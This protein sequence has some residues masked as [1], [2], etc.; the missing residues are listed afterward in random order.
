[1]YHAGSR[2]VCAELYSARHTDAETVNAY[3]PQFV[4]HNNS[5]RYPEMAAIVWHGA[6][7]SEDGNLI[8]DGRIW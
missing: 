1:M 6:G 2:N 3:I 4:I 8:A 5:Q 7:V